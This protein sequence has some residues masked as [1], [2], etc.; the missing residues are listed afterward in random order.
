MQGN[1]RRI[2]R[3]TTATAAPDLLCFC[4]GN[5]IDFDAAEPAKTG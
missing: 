3:T 1:F 5:V 4:N 2:V